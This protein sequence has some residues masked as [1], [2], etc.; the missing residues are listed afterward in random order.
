MPAWAVRAES[1]ELANNS[2]LLSL[3]NLSSVRISTDSSEN[4]ALS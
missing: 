2:A 4:V 3:V 1:V